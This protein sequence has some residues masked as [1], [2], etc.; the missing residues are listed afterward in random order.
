MT[1]TMRDVAHHA[2]VSIKT[3]SRVVNS[4]GEI[5]S[6]TRQ[7]VLKVVEELGY[8][9][10]LVA[11]SLVTRR[12]GIFG[13]VI[14]DITNP[15]FAELTRGVQQVAR[16]AGHSLIICSVDESYDLEVQAVRSLISQ[17][18]DGIVMHCS[19]VSQLTLPV[20]AKSLPDSL[21]VVAINTKDI[22]GS[23]SRLE[24][25]NYEGA[26]LAMDYL[27]A[28]GH[29]RIGMLGPL[30]LE[31]DTPR[32]VRGYRDA[33]AQRGLRADPCWET[34]VTPTISAGYASAR[35][36]LTQQPE[37]TALFCYNDLMAIGALRACSELGRRVPDDI[38][39]VGYDDI[40]LA[41]L[42]T[43]ALT[44]VRVEKNALGQRAMHMLLEQI[45]N[46][47]HATVRE[48]FDVALIVRESA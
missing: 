17:S 44:T 3:V 18:V 45:A 12:T 34:H 19:F 24:T 2:G 46:P 48:E 36:L 28:H 4:E 25:R 14:P 8:R 29:T 7:R 43:P 42:V 38:A 37:L 39:V 35:A 26:R 21:P 41:E 47:E 27:F 32:R 6:D 5:S 15:F 33:F 13:L 40:Q 20:I 11:R 22:R 30:M 31:N 9:P 23:F 1:I 10:N 16:D